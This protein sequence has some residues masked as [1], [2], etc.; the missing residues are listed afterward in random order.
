MNS[1]DNSKEINTERI[2]DN[3]PNDDASSEQEALMDK[4]VLETVNRFNKQ[5]GINRGRLKVDDEKIFV[6]GSDDQT[7]KEAEV[8]TESPFKQYNL[9]DKKTIIGMKEKG[10]FFD[11]DLVWKKGDTIHMG[12]DQMG[13]DHTL[14]PGDVHA[15]EGEVTIKKFPIHEVYYVLYDRKIIKCKVVG[16]T[17]N[18]TY[19]QNMNS[20]NVD[21]ILLLERMDLGNS[22]SSDR[23]IKLKQSDLFSSPLELVK[24]LG[25]VSYEGTSSMSENTFDEYQSVAVSTKFY[26]KGRPVNYPAL[27]M[28]GE[29]GEVAE[30]V[31]KIERDKDNVYSDEDKVELMKELGDVLWYVTALA[32]D[33]G[34]NLKD[35]A[36][37]NIQ[38]ILYRRAHNKVSGSGDNR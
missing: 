33:L 19:G 32:T 31:G 14:T 35:V 11:R 27:K 9:I 4:I 36:N 1:E 20:A 15:T 22:L 7:S 10:K 12:M 29:A 30:K 6:A 16:G 21:H 3:V 18:L 8:K 13:V 24:S 23:Y 37:M 17:L 25:Y 34:Y 2:N 38:K 28:N 5:Y 26:G